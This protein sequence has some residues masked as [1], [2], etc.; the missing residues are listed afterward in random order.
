LATSC[1]STVLVV[2]LSGEDVGEGDGAQSVASSTTWAFT[3]RSPASSARGG[4]R[5]CAAARAS[6]GVA[7]RPSRA[8][9]PSLCQAREPCLVGR[10]PAP[11]VL[12][13]RP[14]Q[15]AVV[16]VGVRLGIDREGVCE[17]QGR[18]LYGGVLVRMRPIVEE[19]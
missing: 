11:V 2:M 14:T 13:E 6:S 12:E 5:R 8:L 16:A 10:E 9:E 3:W 7:P 17:P 15:L 19:V 18:Q 1:A 4:A